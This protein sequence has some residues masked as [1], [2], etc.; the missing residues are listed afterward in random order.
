M[1]NNVHVSRTQVVIVMMVVM[2]VVM[3]MCM[4]SVTMFVVSGTMQQPGAEQVDDQA[5]NSNQ[6]G[7][8]EADLRGGQ[9]PLE[10]FDNHQQ[11]D[12][13]KH[14]G[15]GITSQNTDLAGAETVAVVVG[16]N[17]RV[18]VGKRGNTESEK[19]RSHMPAIGEQSHGAEQPAA[20]NLDDH[21][22]QSQP[23]DPV[24]VAFRN[25]IVL[26]EMMGM[27]FLD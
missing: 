22:H 13:T 7:F 15:T 27:C 11:R 25:R 1:S 24:G 19:V 8:V 4:V 6:Q 21:H 10:G 14:D 2:T 23:D 20:D 3:V 26:M 12:N 5:D 9:Q 16:M 18:V 17:S